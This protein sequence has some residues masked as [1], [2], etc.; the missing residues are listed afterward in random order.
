MKLKLILASLVVSLGL[1]INANAADMLTKKEAMKIV[2]PFYEFL[3]GANNEKEVRKSISTKWKS[4]SANTKDAYKGLDDNLKFLGG[5]VRAMIP[6]LKWEI[7]D[8]MVSGDTII[9]RGEATGTPAGKNFFGADIQGGKSFRI[10]SID[11]HKVKDGQIV[12]SYHIE[13][14][15]SAIN[16][17]R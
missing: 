4:F 3:S 13:D 17:V 16:Q 7:K 12:K 6:N 9:I 14:W 8:L 1:S 11:M 15:F 2:K 5:P 10:M